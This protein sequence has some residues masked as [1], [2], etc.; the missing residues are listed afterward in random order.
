[1]ALLVLFVLGTTIGWL[2]S[3]L[4]R[5]EAAGAILRQMGIGIVVAIGCGLAVN[6]GSV[7]GGLSLLALGVAAGVTIAVLVF[8]HAVL[9]RGADVEA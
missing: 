9:S 8:Y 2:A 1:M 4:A 6:S 5:T 3:I 7:L